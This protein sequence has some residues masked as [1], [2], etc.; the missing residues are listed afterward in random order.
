MFFFWKGGRL[1]INILLIANSPAFD[2]KT[3]LPFNEY[4]KKKL[5]KITCV[6]EYG[7]CDMKKWKSEWRFKITVCI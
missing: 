2:K 3:K 5:V 7:V 1:G 6:S 4:N